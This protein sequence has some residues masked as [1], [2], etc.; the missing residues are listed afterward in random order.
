MKEQLQPVQFFFIAACLSL[1]L[2]AC[3]ESLPQ[4]SAIAAVTTPDELLTRFGEPEARYRKQ[5]MIDVMSIQEQLAGI[6]AQ[7]V[8]QQWIYSSLGSAEANSGSNV[9]AT[10]PGKTVIEFRE[11]GDELILYY[12]PYWL[13]NEHYQERFQNSES[14]LGGE[15]TF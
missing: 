8:A 4:H 5:R 12:A 3:S 11:S 14:W 2:S 6:P 9:T 15:N 13:S 1:L 7:F 10:E